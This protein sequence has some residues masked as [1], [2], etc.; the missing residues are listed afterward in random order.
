MVQAR[1]GGPF[2]LSGTLNPEF[3]FRTRTIGSASTSRCILGPGD[4]TL[5]DEEEL[6]LLVL[7]LLPAQAEAQEKVG[8]MMLEA[9]LVVGSS[10]RYV[11]IKGAAHLAG[12]RDVLAGRH[13]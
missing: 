11:G 7:A 10:A 6:S 3:R 13:R 12:I 1:S 2:A 5:A 9:G 8:R 4:R